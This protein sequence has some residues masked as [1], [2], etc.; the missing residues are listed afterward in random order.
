MLRELSCSAPDGVFTDGFQACGS[1]R[2][3]RRSAQLKVRFCGS[4][5]KEKCDCLR[6]YSTWPPVSPPP[7][8]VKTNHELGAAII[9]QYSPKDYVLDLLPSAD[10]GGSNFAI[11]WRPRRT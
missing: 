5:W 3:M 9:P 4:C 6:V 1:T 7:S 11:P 10:D 2:A 8:S